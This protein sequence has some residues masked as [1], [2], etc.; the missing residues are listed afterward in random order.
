M[1]LC[2]NLRWNEEPFHVTDDV[3]V[4]EL[5][6]VDGPEEVQVVEGIQWHVVLVD[7]VWELLVEV[8][9]ILPKKTQVRL[10]Q[11]TLKQ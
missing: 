11:N 1:F 3:L 7:D 10:S 5:V 8:V 9:D 4:N 6:D 2:C